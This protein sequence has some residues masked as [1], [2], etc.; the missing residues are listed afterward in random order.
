MGRVTFR[1]S[2][3]R[4]EHFEMIKTLN[5]LIEL[6]NDG[7]YKEF[8]KLLLVI[9]SFLAFCGTLFVLLIT[10]IV[11]NFETIIFLTIITVGLISWALTRKLKVEQP[12]PLPPTKKPIQLHYGQL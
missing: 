3:K 10:F 12:R 5:K 7:E 4:K 2:L 6:L 11:N 1:Y 8:F 9:L